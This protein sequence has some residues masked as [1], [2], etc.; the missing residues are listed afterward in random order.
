[1]GKEFSP[2]GFV[3]LELRDQEGQ[4]VLAEKNFPAL[5]KIIESGLLPPKEIWRLF[6]GVHNS[7][8]GS[9]FFPHFRVDTALDIVG[10]RLSMAYDDIRRD[11]KRALHI[12]RTNNYLAA[13]K[14]AFGAFVWVEI[15]HGGFE[16]FDGEHN[17]EF[18]LGRITAQG[19]RVSGPDNYKE[20][21]RYF[22]EYRRKM[23]IKK[24]LFTR[25]HLAWFLNRLAGVR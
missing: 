22:A 16:R 23:E 1:M 18:D 9:I 6:H 19:F 13:C 12:E 5:E 17:Y 3:P 8:W 10:I 7:V 11:R 4:V 25:Y 20:T 14:Q 21:L 2:I 15:G 24:D